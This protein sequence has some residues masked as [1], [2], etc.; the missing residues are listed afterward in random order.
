IKLSRKLDELLLNYK[1]EQIIELAAGYS[2]RGLRMTL[3]NKKLV[4][5]ES[6][7]SSVMSNKR[8]FFKKIESNE[9]IRLSKNHHLSIIDVLKDDLVKKLGK[10]LNK[11]K[12]TLIIS[13]TLNS[14]LSPEEYAHVVNQINA[15]AEDFDEFVY[16]SHQGTGMLSG[17][18]GKLLLFY[19][20][21]ISK[22]RSYVHFSN[23]KEIKNY[24][25]G[26][27]FSNIKV[28]TDKSVSQMFY[29]VKK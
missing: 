27:G 20:D 6:D 8:R 29:L 28:I 1:P 26:K 4:Y 17:I 18:L 21:R 22:T 13:E 24:F 25:K 7:F 9:K 14:Y 10:L 15:L 3:K 23:Q 2:T 19:R 16:L 11:E 12:R 5:I